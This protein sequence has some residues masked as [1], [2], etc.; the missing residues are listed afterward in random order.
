MAWRKAHW[1]NWAFEVASVAGS[2]V[3]FGRG[4]FQGARGGPGSD[5]FIQ[6]VREE[7]DDPTEFYFDVAAQR[8]YVVSNATSK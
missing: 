2:T 6:N 3:K 8:L 5:Y 4:G 1:A 7:L